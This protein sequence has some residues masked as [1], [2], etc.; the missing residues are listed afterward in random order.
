MIT[1]SLIVLKKLWLKAGSL[2]GF[3]T[4]F[5]EN[6]WEHLAENF[7]FPISLPDMED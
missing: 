4:N 5:Q 2:S 6:S 7:P 1:D 3:L